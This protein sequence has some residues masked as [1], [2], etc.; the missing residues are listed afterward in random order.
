MLTERFDQA[1]V[2]AHSMH[3]GHLR[4]ATGI[5]YVT[6][7]MAVAALAVEDAATDPALA[8][9]V[10]DIAIAALLHDVVEDTQASLEQVAARFGDRVAAIVDG[11]SDTDQSPKPPWRERKVA[12]LAHLEVA[13]DQT[14]CVSLADKRHNVSALVTDL[15]SFGRVVFERFNAGPDQ[16]IWYYESLLDVFGRRRPGVPTEEFRRQVEQF[17]RLAQGPIT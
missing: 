15:R 13:S 7:L 9:M 12:Y 4:K 8:P 16:Q 1:F 10:E 14:L 6:H 2:W 5:P 11:C 3:R 17:V